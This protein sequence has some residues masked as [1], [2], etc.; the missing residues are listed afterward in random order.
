MKTSFLIENFSVILPA[1]IGITVVMI[2]LAKYMDGPTTE[3]SEEKAKPSVD[4]KLWR[5]VSRMDIT[6]AR[7]GAVF[8]LV[9]V[10]II[11]I[12]VYFF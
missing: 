2:F 4:Q 12:V 8:V 5:D 7:V 1:A 3:E 11:S 6:A 10:L 9:A